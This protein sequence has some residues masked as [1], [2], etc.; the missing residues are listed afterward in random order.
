MRKEY[1]FSAAKRGAAI[2]TKG[3]TRI[4]IF[5]DDAV[6]SR[7][8]EISERSGTGYQTLINDALNAH[9]GLKDEPMTRELV[10]KIVREELASQN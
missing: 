1:D 4:T 10:R 7:F 2:P 3:K 9:L 6:V 8:K 5:L